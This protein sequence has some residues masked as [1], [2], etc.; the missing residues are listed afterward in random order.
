LTGTKPPRRWKKV[1]EHERYRTSRK[2]VW[3]G[4]ALLVVVGMVHLIEAL[5][6]FEDTTY[7]GVL[8]L[9]N[10]GPGTRSVVAAGAF[11]G[12]AVSGRVGLPGLDETEFLEPM[13]ESSRWLSRGSS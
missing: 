10:L 3:V 8:F 11:A 1:V 12:Y 13:G 2:I 6:Y 7:L 5:E 9:A 4:I